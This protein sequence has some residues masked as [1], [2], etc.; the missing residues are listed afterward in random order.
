[1][2]SSVLIAAVISPRGSARQLVELGFQGDVALLVSALMF[3][4]TQRNL[5]RTAS[6][7][8]PLVDE[9]L[10]PALLAQVIDPAPELVARSSPVPATTLLRGQHPQWAGHHHSA[11]PGRF[12]YR[13]QA[14]V[15]LP[16][17]QELR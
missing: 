1:V 7:A 16:W 4:E 9:S 11:T 14:V 15:N 8:F 2:D 5:T 6:A 13:C 17:R 10:R 3:E 12:S